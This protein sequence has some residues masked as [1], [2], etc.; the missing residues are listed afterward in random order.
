[1]LS[2]IRELAGGRLPQ[3]SVARSVVVLVTGT[4]AGQ[5]LTICVMPVITR[6]YTPAQIGTISLFL[7]F[8]GFWAPALS[9][10]YE[11]ALLIAEDDT[12]SHAV[13]RLAVILVIGM[14]V[15]ACPVLYGLQHF[16][17]LGF[18]L[19]PAWAPPMSVLIF[20]GYGIFMVYRSWA[21]R[22]GMVASITGATIVRSGANAAIRVVLGLLGGGVFALFVAETA[23]AWCAMLR[24][25]RGVGGHFA[26]YRPLKLGYVDLR[27]VGRKFIKFPAIETPSTWLDQLGSLLPL[28]MIAA[29]HGASA[30][31]WFGLTRLIVS[32]P[33]SQIGSAVADVLQMKIANAIVADDK[34]AARRFFYLLLRKLALVG[35]VPLFVSIALG[36]LAVPGVFGEEWSQ[37]GLAV[38]VIAP[39]MYLAFVVSPLSRIV[40]VLQ[41]Q[42]YKLAYDSC[43][44]FLLFSAYLI[45]TGMRLSFIEMVAVVSAAESLGYLIYAVVLILIVKQKLSQ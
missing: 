7:A 17:V 33:N 14:S 10:R 41:V 35:L 21:L 29:T 25:I 19:V 45:S 42:E 24:L 23:G 22:A 39:W 1:M 16:N 13:H 6:L 31:G 15:V 34:D 27:R 20:L 3:G 26:E 12:E 18:G 28:P 32:A 40:S 5:L 8:F 4:T 44:V 43:V 38:A 37:A 11:Y 2:K 9:L 36:P 30:A